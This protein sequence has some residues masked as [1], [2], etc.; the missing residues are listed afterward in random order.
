[1]KKLYKVAEKLAA[2]ALGQY[3]VEVTF[4][5]KNEAAFDPTLG[6]KT[7]NTVVFTGFGVKSG[8]TKNEI[9]GTVVKTGDVKLLLENTDIIPKVGDEAAV[10]GSGTF[11]IINIDILSPAEETILY[12][13]QLRV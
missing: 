2:K 5:Q 1:M 4:T 8:Y 12:E 11:R 6:Q 9:D 13:L 10:N 3:G 7:S